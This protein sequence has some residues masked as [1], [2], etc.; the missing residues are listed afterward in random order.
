MS[1]KKKIINYGAA[2]YIGSHIIN[3]LNQ[4]DY[5]IHLDRNKVK[6]NLKKIQNRFRK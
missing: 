5:E 1:V 3:F 6:F 4:L 2:G